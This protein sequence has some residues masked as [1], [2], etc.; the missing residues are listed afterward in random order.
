MSNA[1]ILIA[2]LIFLFPVSVLSLGF[3]EPFVRQANAANAVGEASCSDQA[4]R[5]DESCVLV[6]VR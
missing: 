5:L 1:F 6:T 3:N 2:R 4:P